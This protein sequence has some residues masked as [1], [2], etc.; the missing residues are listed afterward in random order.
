MKSR[1]SIIRWVLPSWV[2][3]LVVSTCLAIFQYQQSTEGVS[4]ASK[5]LARCHQLATQIEFLRT[6]K[7]IALER[8]VSPANISSQLT[9]ATQAAGISELQVQEVQHLPPVQIA[10][11]DFRRD[12]TILRFR[13][14]TLQILTNLLL[15]LQSQSQPQIPTS[16]V[17]KSPG[18]GPGRSVEETWTIELVLT[19]LTFAAQSSDKSPVR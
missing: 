4:V 19:R 8:P 10:E 16:L 2:A 1:V 18:D 9:Q 3:I 7:S 5:N 6:S 14:V 17:L 12:D 11:T 13:S 15:Q